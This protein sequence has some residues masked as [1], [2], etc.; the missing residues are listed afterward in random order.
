QIHA[1]LARGRLTALAS[2]LS[3]GDQQRLNLRAPLADLARQMPVRILTGC[4]DAVL[5]WQD[6]LDVAPEIA[7]HVFARAGHM[8]HW[9][10]PKA[11]AAI[12]AKGIIDD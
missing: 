9:D 1:D 5:D 7:L 8:P 6:A 4:E 3:H 10:D 12:I 11:A 2:D